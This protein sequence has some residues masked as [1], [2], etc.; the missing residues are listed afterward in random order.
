MSR[1]P[2]V[3]TYTPKVLEEE[4]YLHLRPTM[5]SYSSGI[6][7]VQVVKLVKTQDARVAP[8]DY[9][10]KLTVSVPSS[11]FDEAMPSARVELEPGQVVPV[12]VVPDEPEPESGEG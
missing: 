5:S 9:I 1:R 4:I 6:R 2:K 3:D 10:V 8:G 11:F 12:M 7:G